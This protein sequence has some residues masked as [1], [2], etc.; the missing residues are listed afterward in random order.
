[1][2]DNSN[3]ELFKSD[4][5]GDYLDDDDS[6]YTTADNFDPDI[7]SCSDKSTELIHPGDLILYYCPI[8]VTGNLC[9]LRETTILAVNPKKPYP[10]VLSNGDGI[11]STTNV[12]CIKVF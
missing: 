1:M 7:L 4:T 3:K 12:K 5:N 8:F 9:G 2:L 6:A 11:P 10:L